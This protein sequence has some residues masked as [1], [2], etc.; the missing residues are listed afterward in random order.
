MNAVDSWYGIQEFTAMK[1][2]KSCE[3]ETSLLVGFYK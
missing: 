1:Q 2:Q 3:I